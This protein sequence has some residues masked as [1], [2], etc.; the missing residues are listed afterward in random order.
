MVL[1]NKTLTL[2]SKNIAFEI[3][4]VLGNGWTQVY[5]QTEN[6]RH[7][8]GAESFEYIL[9]HLLAMLD[10]KTQNTDGLINSECV[11]WVLSLSERHNLI[12][13]N[14]SGETMKLYIQNKNAEITFIFDLSGEDK[15]IWKEKLINRTQLL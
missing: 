5:L 10:E 7:F 14:K 8:L 2:Q 4:P 6:K 13:A 3:I 12:Y 1:E 15:K 11:F 9:Q